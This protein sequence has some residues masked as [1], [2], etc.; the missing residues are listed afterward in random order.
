MVSLLDTTER[1][2]KAEEQLQIERD[3]RLAVEAA[4]ADLER[5]SRHLAQARDR[6]DQA[7]RAKSRFLAGM[8]HELRTPLNG[9][10]GYAQLL[11]MEGG[12][13]S[14][15]AERVDAMLRAGRHLLEMITC[16]L[17]ISEIEAG[18]VELQAISFDVQSVA[19]A[20]LDLIR[21]IA[22]SKGLMLSITSAPGTRRELVADPTRLRQVL[23]NLLGNAA[24]FTSHGAIEL[25]LGP[26][27][28]ASTLRIE[29][30][31]TGA[32]IPAEQRQRLFND[33]ERLDNAVTRT[34][35]GSGLGLALSARLAVLMGGR[36][37]HDDNPGGGSVFW[38]ELP[39]NL[40]NPAHLGVAAYPDRQDVG[41]AP[42]PT[43]P[44]H[45]LV[46]DDV[47]MN[48]DIGE[49]FLRS[50]GHEVTCAEDGA[51]AVALVATKDFDVVVM[52]VRMPQMDGLEAT[53]R[54]R[55]MEG[56]RGQVPIVALTAHAFKEQIRDCHAAGMDGHLAK[57]FDMET[58]ISAVANAVAAKR[59]R[60][61]EWRGAIVPNPSPVDPETTLITPEPPVV[62]RHV[63]ERTAAFLAPEKVADYIQTIR[64]KGEMLLHDLREADAVAR[65]GGGI[66]HSAHALAGSAAMFGFER[67]AAASRSFEREVRSG[68][69]E[70][71]ALAD[72]LCAAVESTLKEI[73][74]AQAV[75][76]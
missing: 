34:A 57:P 27:T 20:C 40:P 1:K 52:D 74:N 62:N 46:V 75:T 18:H 66:A 6:A 36:L 26:G 58:L 70:S 4:N 43:R 38:L 56:P 23:F 63:F 39:S 68:S 71:G 42:L 33:F 10:L 3:N 15:Q 25:R 22:E 9:I 55:A 11:H 72:Q 48:R 5:L 8:S 67:L 54:I 60:D 53:R 65:N 49:S 51:E 29:V 28:E 19:E 76:C 16:V 64:D 30:V 47:L 37:G 45:V 17:D 32:G 69:A 31:D 59:Q 61:T 14:A 41:A 35:E 44:L 13:N 50:A 24:K 21:P 12:L 73:E 2:R 7:N